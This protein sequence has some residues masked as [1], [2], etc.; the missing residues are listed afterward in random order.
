MKQFY[1]NLTAGILAQNLDFEKAS[2]DILFAEEKA[3]K[4]F[5][6]IIS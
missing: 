5:A 4:P 3:F 6:H 2:K 1:L